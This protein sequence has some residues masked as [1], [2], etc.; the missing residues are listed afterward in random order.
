MTAKKSTSPR[1]PKFSAATPESKR[2]REILFG[3]FLILISLLLFIAFTS[4]F[5]SWKQ[6]QSTLNALTDRTV[7]SANILSKLGAAVSHFLIFKSFGLAAY[8]LAYLFGIT[9]LI[10]FFNTK[11][12]R[13]LAQWTWGLYYSLWF[14]L[15]FGYYSKILPVFSGVMGFEIADFISDYIGSIG[16]GTLLVFGS[17]I[18]IVLHWKVTPEALILKIKPLFKKSN[19]PT[20]ETIVSKYMDYLLT[21]GEKPKSVYQFMKEIDLEESDFYSISSSFEDIEIKIFTLFYENT[22]N[23]LKKNPEFDKYDSK[24]QLLSF[25]F[26]FFENLTANRSYVLLS[27]KNEKMKLKGLKKLSGLKKSF[28]H[29]IDSLNIEKI[30]L[31]QEK[32]QRI[33][34]KG[35]EEGFWLQLLLTMK[36]WMEDTSSSF[37]KTDLFIEKSI[38]ATFDIINTAPIKSFFDFGK[39]IYKERTNF[40]L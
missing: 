5:F 11:K 39:F 26:T 23:L 20:E 35:F 31:K 22:I 25:Y 33:Q 6:D 36:F 15:L 7:E 27:L 1:L 14:A 32:L 34:D 3:G 13:L 28:K 37:E 40:K 18:F 17:L 16:M 38:Q 2:T 4:Y 9:G 19:N 21:K 8:I 12:E 30:D 29:F 24:E 10:F